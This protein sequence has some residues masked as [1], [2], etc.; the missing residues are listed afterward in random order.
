[1]NS[2]SQRGQL[3]RVVTNARVPDR[4]RPTET[5]ITGNL[6]STQEAGSAENGGPNERGA[7]TLSLDNLNIEGIID[8]ASRGRSSSLRSALPSMRHGRVMLIYIKPPG[9]IDR[10][11]YLK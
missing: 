11:I 6:I 7:V 9:T 5:P 10:H 2:N 8:A 4:A 1:M 3:T